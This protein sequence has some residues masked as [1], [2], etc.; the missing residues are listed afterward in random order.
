MGS[1]I[2][3]VNS[4]NFFVRH[5]G[6]KD[7]P[8]IILCH[9]LM[10]NHHMWDHTVP[11]LHSAGFS[12]LRYDHVGHNKTTF[13]T[14]EAIEREYHFDDFTRHIHTIL[15]RVSPG[16]HPFAII[17]CSIGG[18]LALRY[19]QMYPGQLKKVISCDAPGLSSLPAG[20]PLWKER[21]AQFKA[22]GVE[23]LAKA[24]VQRW[25]PDPCPDGVREAMLEQTL[26]C[27][28]EGYK[29][30]ANAVTNY[31]YDSGLAEIKTEQVMV[32]AGQNDTAIGPR[33][34]L[35]RVAEQIAGAKYFLMEDVG[36]IPPFHDP[37]AFNKVML[38]FLQSGSRDSK[39]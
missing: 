1:Q 26:A 25:M 11:A 33:E 22:E 29:A 24:T 19:A 4:I 8:L 30:Y 16:K 20:K 15:E 37:G 18:V 38:D 32:L 17:G 31:D 28:Y 9:A 14:P 35:V 5:E 23:N 2:I 13:A 10:A 36:H 27:T 7:R 39:F 21:M 6:P 34:I 12:T 3:S